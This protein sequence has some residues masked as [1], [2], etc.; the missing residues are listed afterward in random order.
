[1]KSVACALRWRSNASLR[2]ATAQKALALT[3]T[4][5]RVPFDV[6]VGVV[7]S[8]IGWRTNEMSTCERPDPLHPNATDLALRVAGAKSELRVAIAI[9]VPF[10]HRG[11]SPAKAQKCFSGE[12]VSVLLWRRAGL[13]VRRSLDYLCSR[14]VRAIKYLGLYRHEALSMWWQAAMLALGCCSAI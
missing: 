7:G 3:P 5:C 1:V 9:Q 8:L 11:T 4:F 10:Q 2:L 12:A 14:L 13:A 6:H